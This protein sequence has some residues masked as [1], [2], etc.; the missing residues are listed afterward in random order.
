MTFKYFSRLF[1]LLSLVLFGMVACNRVYE[2]EQPVVSHGR[3]RGIVT[4][5][6][7][8]QTGESINQDNV[9]NED[10]VN[11]IRLI[12][13][14]KEDGDVVH[15]EVHPLADLIN[16]RKEIALPTGEYDFFFVA[17]ET[18]QMTTALDAVTFRDAL[19]RNLLAHIPS[20]SSLMEGIDRN[21]GIPMTA[22]LS[23][24][25]TVN[26]KTGNSLRLNVKLVRTLA[27]LTLN[28]QRTLQTA[29]AQKG[30]PTEEAAPVTVTSM[31]LLNIAGDYPLFVDNN[32]LRSPQ[33]TRE[34][35]F[36][37]NISPNGNGKISRVFYVPEYVAQQ[38]SALK[39][40]V[41]FAKHGETKT[42]S[43]AFS[44][45]SNAAKTNFS[46]AGY[47]DAL[48]GQADAASMVRNTHYQ[49][50]IEVKGWEE[51]VARFNWSV[52]PWEKE[53]STK[54]FTPAVVENNNN[55]L[56]ATNP[57]ITIQSGHPNWININPDRTDFVTLK[58]K[59]K[60]PSGA[61]WRFTLTNNLD[62]NFDD[63]STTYGLTSDQQITITVRARKPWTGVLR[64][65]ELYLIVDGKEVPILGAGVGPGNRILI[66]QT[67]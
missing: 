62:F 52:Q 45:K 28:I 38:S 19:F 48:K 24:T 51:N 66:R 55:N 7:R 64:S 56:A 12:I 9:D 1:L 57:G 43:G 46:D 39:Y 2:E 59:V 21:V 5:N 30:Q 29:G 20:P 37:T 8:A 14:L 34:Q 36:T 13:C 41:T 10:R 33:S 65:T 53:T 31:K 35:T 11:K 22:R 3:A 47:S 27:K 23:G 40:E 63:E 15:N 49:A 4:F 60:T 6:T 50:D 25:V 54:D 18:P 61:H 44:P 32:A 67:S 17:N 42:I 58:F 16:F 26:H